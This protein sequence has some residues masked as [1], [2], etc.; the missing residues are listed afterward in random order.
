MPSS[1]RTRLSPNL[2]RIST[3][4]AAAQPGSRRPTYYYYYYCY[5]LV[6]GV[7]TCRKKTRDC[8]TRLSKGIRRAG[9]NEGPGDSGGLGPA[10]K[11]AP[12]PATLWQRYIYGQL[13]FTQ[14]ETL[15]ALWPVEGGRAAAG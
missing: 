4:T 14:R 2:A 11:R 1:K 3:G 5:L 6:G 9:G 10:P 7:A 12:L 8:P 15:Q 13:V